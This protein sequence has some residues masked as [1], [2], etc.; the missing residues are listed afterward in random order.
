M[1]SLWQLELKLQRGPNE[2]ILFDRQ[3]SF[4]IDYMD[5]WQKSE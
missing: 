4:S 3:G 5:I 2:I 1:P